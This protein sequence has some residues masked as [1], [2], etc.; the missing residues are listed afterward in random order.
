VIV[1]HP[2]ARIGRTLG[3]GAAGS[4]SIVYVLAVSAD[5]QVFYD[6][7]AT[8]GRDGSTVKAMMLAGPEPRSIL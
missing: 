7:S 4:K 5:L 1:G 2:R 8:T 6:N 3:G